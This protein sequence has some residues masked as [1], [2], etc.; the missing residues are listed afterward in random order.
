MLW[1]CIRS[2]HMLD[3]D[4]KGPFLRRKLSLV[5]HDVPSGPPTASQ[6]DSV[7]PAHLNAP[8]GATKMVIH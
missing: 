6:C 3:G 5:H 4:E 2:G 1:K 8:Q 7:H